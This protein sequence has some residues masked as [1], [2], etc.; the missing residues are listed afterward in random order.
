MATG[1]SL[2]GFPAVDGDWINA[3]F[4]GELGSAYLALSEVFGECHGY[5][6][7]TMAHNGKD[8]FG[9][10]GRVPNYPM[11]SG[12]C[13]LLKIVLASHCRCGMVAPHTKEP[14]T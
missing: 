2:A 4:S 8:Y 13:R 9:G 5:G 14:L 7:T 12:A 11:I 3:N 1:E 10:A 6:H